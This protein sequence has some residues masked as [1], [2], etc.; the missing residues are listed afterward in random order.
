MP[1][2]LLVVADDH[3][4]GDQS[5][6]GVMDDVSTPGLDRLASLG[7]RCTSAY[8]A[9]PIC[10]PSR[11]AILTGAYPQR[12]GSYWFDSAVYPSG[13]VTLAEQLGA[14]GYRTGYFGKVHY[15]E[16]DVRF[17][18]ASPN[19]HGFDEALYSLAGQQIG[20]VHYLK[21]TRADAEEYGES[22]KAMGVG[23]LLENDGELESSEL[24][25]RLFGR[26]AREFM[27]A[28]DERPFFCYVAFNAV[29][30]FCF[31]LPP[32]ELEARG[33][34]PHPDWM[35]DVSEYLDWYDGAI[36][37]KLGEQGRDYYRAQL[38]IMDA[39]INAFIDHL[40]AAGQLDNTVI[41]Y[42]S[43]NGG[44]HETYASNAPLR[45][46][47]YS[48]LEGGVRVPYIVSWPGGGIP[49]GVESDGLTSSMDLM[50]TFS[51]IVGR[52]APDEIDGISQLDA[53]RQ[54]DVP[55][56]EL[57]HWD[58]G[59]QWSVRDERWKLHWVDADEPTAAAI[60]KVEKVHLGRGQSLFDLIND[61]GEST[62]VSA[63][64]P[65]IVDRL[66]A[67]HEAWRAEMKSAEAS[68]ATR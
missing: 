54:A 20:R 30:N 44:G 24:T 66:T 36:Y 52:P 11:S 51:E 29:H 61:P 56:H 12:W 10:S 45:G 9:A 47:K 42:L 68:R 60:E 17:G 48:L 2:I 6:L 34:D 8:V 26:R 25:T 19:H 5:G 27:A 14:A 3:G 38:E 32:E 64:H 46:M 31:Q 63:D 62:D 50:P 67:A 43:D 40:E 35:A 23:P 4:Y 65:D 58:N 13:A 39:E 15:G 7:V 16:T 37:P 33:L 22:A 49:G 21:H 57:L 18:E 55:T 28:D 53:W 1:N 59:F 41:V